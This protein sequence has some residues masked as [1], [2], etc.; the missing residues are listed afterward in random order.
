[1]LLALGVT[2]CNQGDS[3]SSVAVDGAVAKLQQAYDSLGALIPDPSNITTGFEVP[4]TL[5][6]SV[7]AEWSS[8]EPGVISFGTP[9]GGFSVATVNRPAKDAG[10]AVVTI[11][12]IL[13][14]Q[15][16]LTSEMLHQTWDIDLTVKENTVAELV[17][18]NVDDILA[19][20][21]PVYDGELSVTLNDMTIFAKSAGE[22]FAYDGTG[23]IQVYAGAASTMSVGK[24]YMIS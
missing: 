15:S 3:S 5:A 21:D 13:S 12:A 9:A 18:D 19:I 17:I 6:N 10:D 2:A 4:V 23:I 22:A 16:E 1:M 11:S 24:A 7:T 20:I 14:L 8:D